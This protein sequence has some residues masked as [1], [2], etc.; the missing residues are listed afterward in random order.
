MIAYLKFIEKLF[1]MSKVCEHKFEYEDPNHEGYSMTEVDLY[2]AVGRQGVAYSLRKNLDSGFYEIF[3]FEHEDP[4]SEDSV[5]CK[6][7]LDSMIEKA[8]QLEEGATGS[9]GFE[10]GHSPNL[11]EE[12]PEEWP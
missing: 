3:D 6:G 7:D 11:Y 2:P 5:L 10:Y 9:S 8:H 1:S 12:C 4:Y